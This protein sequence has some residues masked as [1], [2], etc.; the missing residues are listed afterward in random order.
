MPSLACLP[1]LPHSLCISQPQENCNADELIKQYLA[2][3]DAE[4]NEA[5]EEGG[6]EMAEAEMDDDDEMEEE[7]AGI[8]R[9]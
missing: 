7:L 1:T 8:A 2:E 4:T 5:D 6:E 3:M 9:P